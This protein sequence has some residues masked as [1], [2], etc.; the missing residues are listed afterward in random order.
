MTTITDEQVEV[1][2]ARWF[3]DGSAWNRQMTPE[4]QR[5]MRASM[6]AAL[7]AAEGA[8]WREPSEALPKKPGENRYE[9]VPCL[10][11]HNGYVVIS[12]WNCDHA[13]WDDQDGDDFM[14]APGEVKRWRHL[15]ATPKETSHD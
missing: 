1:A 8:A 5:D 11:E 3:D 6:R 4:T 12:M 7:E 15:P 10:I 14:A 2:L 13:C 9:L